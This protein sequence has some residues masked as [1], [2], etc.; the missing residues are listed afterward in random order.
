MP[1]TLPPDLTQ[2]DHFWDR[3][4]TLK[5]IKRIAQA[6]LVTPWALLGVTMARA[7][8]AVPPNIMLPPII[9]GPA[10]LNYFVALTGPSG[11]SKSTTIGC[12]YSYISIPEEAEQENLGTGEGLAMVFLELQAQGRG[13]PKILVRNA[14]Q[15][16]VYMVDEVTTL[17]ELGSR[18]GSTIQSVLRT[19]WTGGRLG[20]KNADPTR[21]RKVSAHDYRLTMICGVQPR[22]S[23]VLFNDDGA[24]T[25]QRFT[26]FPTI[27]PFLDVDA[28]EEVD[29]MDI[30]KLLM[31]MPRFSSTHREIKICRDAR[32][33]IRKA[34]IQ[35]QRGE[36]G[37]SLDGH[38]LLCREKTAAALSLI[39]D[40]DIEVT[41][42]W[43]E[44]SGIL[45]EVSGAT[46]SWAASGVYEEQRHA[47][48]SEGNTMG[49]RN[50]QADDAKMAETIARVQDNVLK[51]F[52]ERGEAG[53]TLSSAAAKVS[54]NDRRTQHVE[55]FPDAD[56]NVR[57]VSKSNLDLAWD[58][59]VQRKIITRAKSNRVGGRVYR[60][61][62]DVESNGESFTDTEADN[63]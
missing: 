5:Q 36:S 22:R 6:K 51:H 31:T 16:V 19:A 25:P 4:D 50:S 41:D 24:G 3:H 35:R 14:R 2:F 55:R 17:G 60:L 12:C 18:D 42:Q 21:D 43:W 10:S 40:R 34:H 48:L 9:G 47:A 57:S 59:L 62:K 63:A 44:A 53:V 1:P 29:E 58:D 45:M 32:M 15:G 13:Q 38:L 39:C 33:E 46:R 30:D 54:K 23:S 56:G 8:S 61:T 49:V 11:S 52:D 37:E 7:L 26:W 28:E 27:D 20:A